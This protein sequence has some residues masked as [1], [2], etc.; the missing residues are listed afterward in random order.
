MN[1]HADFSIIGVNIHLR[2]WKGKV[3]NYFVSVRSFG[4]WSDDA[5]KAIDILKKSG[6]CKR[7]IVT[8]VQFSYVIKL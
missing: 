8:S 7:R 5:N 4:N 6:K 1:P 2:P 3:N